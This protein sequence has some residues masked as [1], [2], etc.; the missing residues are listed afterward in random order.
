MKDK[1]KS[2]WHRVP[3]PSSKARKLSTQCGVITGRHPAHF[4][5]VTSTHGPTLF[6][7]FLE[8][9]FLNFFIIHLRNFFLHQNDVEFDFSIGHALVLFAFFKIINKKYNVDHARPNRHPRNWHISI[10]LD[11]KT[12]FSPNPTIIITGKFRNTSNYMK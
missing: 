2:F 8:P 9:P 5:S 10:Y 4:S 7:N 3:P 1:K 11:H 6:L 12:L